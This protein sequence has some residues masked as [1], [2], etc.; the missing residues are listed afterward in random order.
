VDGSNIAAFSSHSFEKPGAMNFFIL[1]MRACVGLVLVAAGAAKLSDRQEFQRTLNS[2]TRAV[3]PG[4]I[5][6][7]IPTAEIL[8]GLLLL[9]QVVATA[10]M[11]A[12]L[13]LTGGFL[14]LSFVMAR[15]EAQPSC[16]CFGELGN[17]RFGWRTV[18]RNAV[19]FAATVI[20][21]SHDAA[22]VERPASTW[23]ILCS[24]TVLLFA[25]AV[26]QASKALSL[27]AE[28]ADVS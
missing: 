13:T 6:L 3:V 12:V 14:I 24:L 20:V 5:A 27:K 18:V 19:L 7:A 10:L 23:R 21:A 16:R 9:N 2:L 4:V 22:S 15:S 1:F 26:A 8:L 25:L 28:E 17:G 11:I